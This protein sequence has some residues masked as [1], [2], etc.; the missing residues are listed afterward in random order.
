MDAEDFLQSHAEW[1]YGSKV[2]TTAPEQPQ[3]WIMSD[4]GFYF[5]LKGD[6]DAE[7]QRQRDRGLKCTV[8]ENQT[9]LS[10]SRIQE[11]LER[12]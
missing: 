7:L 10:M 11:Q 8:H 6:L 4:S 12:K 5:V 2:E 3:T 1:K 9:S